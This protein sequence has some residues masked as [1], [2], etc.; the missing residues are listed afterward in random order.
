MFLGRHHKEPI[1]HDR[2]LYRERNLVER[3]IGW[4]KQ[5]CRLTTRFEKTRAGDIRRR[6][7]LAAKSLRR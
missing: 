3:G 1:D 2:V 6:A 4:L 5:C 7:P